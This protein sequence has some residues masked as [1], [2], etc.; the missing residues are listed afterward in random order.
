MSL[1]T[2]SIDKEQVQELTSS[3]APTSEVPPPS[4]SS[5]QSRQVQGE[6]ARMSRQYERER[7]KS[8]V[9][10]LVSQ[11]FVVHAPQ[12]IKELFRVDMDNTVLNVHPSSTSF[13]SDIP[14]A[15]RK[16]HHDDYLYDHLEGEKDSKRMNTTKGPSSAN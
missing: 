16:R 6:I 11:E 5:K 3:L 12:I 8:D 4:P 14:E 13:N 7:T 15:S 2:L 9:P 1:V 10:D